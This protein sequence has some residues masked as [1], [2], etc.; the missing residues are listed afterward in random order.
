MDT[1]KALIS[2]STP[3]DDAIIAAISSKNPNTTALS[4]AVIKAYGDMAGR[5]ASLEE[6][7]KGLTFVNEIMR[8]SQ[9]GGP[10]TTGLQKS[11]SLASFS[12]L[13]GIIDKMK[14][15]GQE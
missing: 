8:L 15:Y 11:M 5:D 7:K 6:T 2:K 14:Q 13:P 1:I 9:Q 12:T 4:N 3:K 10:W